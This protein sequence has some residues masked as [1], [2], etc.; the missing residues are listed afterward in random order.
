MQSNVGS[1]EALWLRLASVRSDDEGAGVLQQALEEYA[2]SEPAARVDVLRRVKG[3]G[4]VLLEAFDSEDKAR[5]LPIDEKF[6]CDEPLFVS[7]T[8]FPGLKAWQNERAPT[9]TSNGEQQMSTPQMMLEKL[10]VKS[11]LVM[12][13]TAKPSDEFDA[14]TLADVCV[15]EAQRAVQSG[16]A[17]RSATLSYDQG[18]KF[19][20]LLAFPSGSEYALFDSSLGD[21]L[22]DNDGWK[23]ES[24]VSV[25]PEATTWAL[26]ADV[27]AKTWDLPELEPYAAHESQ[28]QQSQRTDDSFDPVRVWLGVGALEKLQNHIRSLPYKL[29]AVTGW[30]QA[31][32]DPLLWGLETEDDMSVIID[33]PGFV[34]DSELGN[35]IDILKDGLALFRKSGCEGVIAYGSGN[36]MDAA[37]A[38][39]A[40]GAMSTEEVERVFSDASAAAENS[41]GFGVIQ[42]GTG[43]KPL[44]LYL[45]PNGIGSEAAYTSTTLLRIG[46]GCTQVEWDPADERIVTSDPRLFRRIIPEL[47]E[48]AANVCLG[49][50]LEAML[51]EATSSTANRLAS[52]GIQLAVKVLMSKSWE[53]ED[54]EGH[55]LSLATGSMMGG[56]AREATGLGL[57]AAL[58]LALECAEQERV[59]EPSFEPLDTNRGSLFARY[60]FHILPC[61]VDSGLAPDVRVEAV[62]ALVVEPP[63]ATRLISFLYRQAQ[64]IAP[65]PKVSRAVASR[66][67]KA[68]AACSVRGFP[69]RSSAS[70][71]EQILFKS[72]VVE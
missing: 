2:D 26:P 5:S 10:G 14:E 46:E 36:V 28:V 43:R 41:G 31:R 34:S 66:V 1:G 67:A 61:V 57:G 23:V 15:E 54:D 3:D 37:R 70:V 53:R 17:L 59:K 25:Y 56:S 63:T 52:E 69:A 33:L 45:V 48:V 19:A 47:V 39:A 29:F 11:V 60:F 7:S 51:A 72:G 49:C 30:N 68:V 50:C 32:L 12:V 22:L 55:Y 62:A 40:L 27:L 42:A 13:G 64:S 71:I 44:P 65:P 18:K 24:F 4:F 21:D 58:A 16:E 6:H 8:S 38:I 9:K 35:T 20:L